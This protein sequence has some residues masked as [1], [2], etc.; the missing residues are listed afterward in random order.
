MTIGKIKTKLEVLEANPSTEQIVHVLHDIVQLLEEKN[1][2]GFK[3][4]KQT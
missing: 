2:I 4:G 3:D 1:E